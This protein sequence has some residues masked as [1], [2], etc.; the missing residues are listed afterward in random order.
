MKSLN[1]LIV[2]DEILI[3]ELI[4]NYL[5]EVGHQVVEFAISYEEAIAMF[6]EHQPNLVLLDIRLYGQK[7]GIDFAN[8]LAA[9]KSTTPYVFLSSQYDQKTLSLALETNPYGYLTKPINK[10]TLWTTVSAAHKLFESKNQ[11][12]LIR[13]FD[14]KNHHLI[15][16]KEIACVEADHVYINVV[17]SDQKVLIIR[18]ALKNLKGKLPENLFV[19]CHRS[20][21][22]NINHIKTWSSS[23]VVMTGGKIIPISRVYKEEIMEALN[24]LNDW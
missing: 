22:I 5:E 7:S 21:L 1:I 6:E 20:Y 9:E 10:E 15:Y 8:Y 23:E 24:G 3:A 11:T 14:G 2:E 12:E 4:K 16:F 18:D 17:L 19:Q 13:L